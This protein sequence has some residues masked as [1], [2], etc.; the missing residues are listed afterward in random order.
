MNTSAGRE[1]SFVDKDMLG[2]MVVKHTARW[3]PFCVGE[4]EKTK[5]K[6]FRRHPHFYCSGGGGSSVT[7]GLLLVTTDTLI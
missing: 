6:G 4:E 7:K 2:W 1:R 3:R 5:K